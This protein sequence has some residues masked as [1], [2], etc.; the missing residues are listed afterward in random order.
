MT[1]TTSPTP[2]RGFLGSIAAGAAVLAAGRWSTAEAAVSIVEVSPPLEGES[3]RDP[4]RGAVAGGE[5][6]GR[7]GITPAIYP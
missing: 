7:F 1:P 2:R 5:S 6:A 4:P 3:R